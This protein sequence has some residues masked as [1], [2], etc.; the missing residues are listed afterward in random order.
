VPLLDL[1]VPTRSYPLPG[2]V[3]ALLREAQKRGERLQRGGRHP[4]FVPCD[5]AGAYAVLAGLATAA[6]APGGL[7][8]EWGS[9]LG[10][11]A[12]LAALLDYDACGLEVE[13]KLVGAARQL[14]ADFELPVEF[15]CAS[16]IPQG[17]CRGRRRQGPFAWLSTQESAGG[18]EL[19]L[20]P[21]DFDV[22]F[23]Y[24]WPDEA[25]FI[26]D[27]FERHGAV[28]AVLV[29]YAGGGS[30]RLRR[31]TACRARRGRGSGP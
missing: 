24:P 27:L 13:E 6:L 11:V 17:A 16:F 2:D 7:L 9:G 20:G 25:G 1:S 14:A 5:Y 29:T 28:G 18:G 31:K 15:A 23:A 8:C 12:C 26:A 19:G 21:E 3:R 10:A 22:V 30:F 4:A